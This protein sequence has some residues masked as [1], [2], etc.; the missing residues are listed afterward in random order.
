MNHGFVKIAAAVPEVRVAD[1]KFNVQ[2]IESLVIQA[3]GHGVEIICL[4]ELC[5]TGY[6]CA[7]LFAQQLL[8]DEAEMGLIQLMNFSRSL[9]II[10]IVGLP[11]CFRGSLV[12]CAAVIQK[13]RIL[14]L[15]PKSYLPNYREFQE[16][17]WFT[18]ASELP[19]DA[20][21]LLCGQ[22]V[23]LSA[24]QLFHTPTCTFGVE[25]CEDLWAPI[26]PS[27][28]QA[29]QGAEII[30]NLSADNDVVG[31]LDYLQG[32]LRQQSARCISGYVYA[33]AGF[34]ESTQDVVF[35]GKAMILECGKFIAEGQRHSLKPQ[36]IESEIDVERL[37]ADRRVNTTFTACSAKEKSAPYHI[38]ETALITQRDFEF[39]RPIN[40]HP[41]VPQGA[42]LDE[43]CREM[44]AIQS[45]GLAK[46]LHHIGCKAVVIGISGGLDST[47]ALL[48]AVNTFDLLGLERHGIVGVTMPG[49]GTTDRTYN[50]AV[51]LMHALGISIQEVNISRS[52]LQHFED[53]NQ[54]PKNH[55]VTYENS[56]ARERTQIL[57]DMANQL[58]G[59]VVGTGDLSELALGWCT[60][61]GDH[62]SMY[63]VNAGVP[64]TLVRHLV[65]WFAQQD[66]LSPA[67]RILLDIVD[68]PISP[69]LIP[70]E[71]TDA[72]TLN[73]Q[74]AQKTE[75][76][77]GPYELHDFFLYYVLRY[78]FRPSKIF[79]LAQ[80]AF[81]N[82][83]PVNILKK[84]LLN[85]YR[86][87]F[88]HQFKRSCLPD[89]PK[90]GSISL[91]PRG[92]WRMPSDASRDA[93]LAECES[94]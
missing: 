59:L 74:I 88:G 86:R 28:Q 44:I 23:M 84:W 11:V 25:L 4:P 67:S 75:D 64:K 8:L 43:R 1:P 46:R 3:E 18:S 22:Q 61:N 77:V 48:I 66:Q 56:Q 58:N 52:V 60:Y 35:S 13:G 83:Y 10:T 51:D 31:K 89:G 36:L 49:F 9:D 85:F 27:C 39:T 73:A 81:G 55:D 94:L 15:V 34:G 21:V 38:V 90:V 29:L 71:E 70:A 14:G 80:Q 2:Q 93:W 20:T 26:P 5:I 32:L 62:M 54:N 69:E 57:M 7:D 91:S 78:G 30:F 53:I 41:F 65:T 72:A 24:R 16:K 92:D 82:T 19:A 37:R 45:E 40:P 17:R 63:G 87:F 76:I 79:F 12:N 50:N 6:T 33:A 68:T 42:D 47:L